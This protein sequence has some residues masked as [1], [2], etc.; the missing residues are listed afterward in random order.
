MTTTPVPEALR[1]AAR[2]T[3]GAWH[4]MTRGDVEAV[5]RELRR[6]H[7]LAA[8]A[9]A[10]QPAPLTSSFV[11]TVPDKCDR[12]V[13]RNNYYH[14]PMAAAPKAAPADDPGAFLDDDGRAMVANSHHYTPENIRALVK[15][16]RAFSD[17]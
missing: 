14:L 1:L 6:L 4:K 16:L 7:A 15:Q 12:I 9:P 8:S 5:G 13:W 10:P 3:E 17:P 11:Q 2:L